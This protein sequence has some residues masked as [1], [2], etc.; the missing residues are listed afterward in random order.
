MLE[1]AAKRYVKSLT[2]I[3]FLRRDE[4]YVICPEKSGGIECAI[5][6]HNGPDGARGSANSFA[7]L[8][9]KANIGHFHSA[10]IIDG[11]YVAGTSSQFNLGY[12]KGPSSWS[13]SHVVTYLNGKRAIVTM[14]DGKWRA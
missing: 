7:R 9:R 1:W 11:V 14:W 13:H 5:H 6:G 3:Q 4:S 12:N 10:G 2:G 8:G